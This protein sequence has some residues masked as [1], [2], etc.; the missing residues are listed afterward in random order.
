ME[1]IVHPTGAEIVYYEAPVIDGIFFG[2]QGL[3]GTK[4]NRFSYQFNRDVHE[5]N[6][7]IYHAYYMGKSG[8]EHV[9]L[10]VTKVNRG[11]GGDRLLSV[12]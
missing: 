7:W 6:R 5:E 1:E 2:Q 11:A 4:R 3:W 9:G 10:T 12:D 8:E